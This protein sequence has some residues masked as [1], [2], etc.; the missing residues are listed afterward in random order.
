MA[1]K[2]PKPQ[3]VKRKAG[4]A[5]KSGT[6]AKKSKNKPR[7]YNLGNGIYRFSKSR[8]YHKKALYKFIGKK[9]P[10][11]VKPKRPTHSVKQIG[12]EK[13][14]GTRTVLLRKRRN[15]YPTADR[16]RKRPSRGLFSKHKRNIRPTLTPGTVC[17]LLAGVHRGKRVVLLRPFKVNGC[18]L[19][20][21]SQRYVIATNLKLDVSSVKLPERVNDAYFKR[22]HQKRAKKEES[23][24]FNVK[25]QTAVDKQLLDVIRKN[26]EKK[27][28]FGYLGSMFGLRSGNLPHKMKF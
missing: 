7:N 14:G 20:R 3:A 21:V 18:P 11:T 22:Q 27:S 25:K 6:P 4:P 5:G 24:I 9:T 28:I 23:D 1:D 19:R 10:K 17:I 8:M 15:Y 26:P 2:Q 12:G 16:M 13:N